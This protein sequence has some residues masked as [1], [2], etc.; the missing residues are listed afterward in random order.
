VNLDHTEILGDTRSKIARD[1]IEIVK[2]GTLFITG[3]KRESILKIFKSYCL[4]KQAYFLTVK[5]LRKRFFVRNLSPSYQKENASLAINAAEILNKQGLFTISQ[6]AIVEGLRK[7]SIIGRFHKVGTNPMTLFDIAHNPHG[8]E[9]LVR[10]LEHMKHD[11]LIVVLGIMHDKDHNRI[12]HAIQKIAD[13]IVFTIP[14]IERSWK[15]ADIKRYQRKSDFCIPHSKSAYRY[16]RKIAEK[17]DLIV[18]TGSS[19]LVGEIIP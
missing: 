8:V 2:K 9:T 16:A 19:Y 18:V 13:I 6:K 10:E 15:D 12:V 11:K 4:K 14:K 3:E 17:N 7:F 5:D 1:K